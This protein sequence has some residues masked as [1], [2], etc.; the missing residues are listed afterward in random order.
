MTSE[1]ASE[2]HLIILPE[3]SVFN[4][5][6][7][8][9]MDSLVTDDSGE[10]PDTKKSVKLIIGVAGLAIATVATKSLVQNIT[11]GDVVNFLN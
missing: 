10:I 2:D 9:F 11:F 4:S 1:N 3:D 8:E 7:G 5:G 6:F